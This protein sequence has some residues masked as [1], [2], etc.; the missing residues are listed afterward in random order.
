MGSLLEEGE[1][2]SEFVSFHMEYAEEKILG[3][4]SHNCARDAVGM[5]ALDSN[6]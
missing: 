3:V 1:S 6:G 2:T 4:V 5:R